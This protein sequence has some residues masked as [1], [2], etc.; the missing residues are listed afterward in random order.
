M[1]FI[2]SDWYSTFTNLS[3]NAFKM[4]LV[5]ESL[6]PVGVTK[7]KSLLQEKCIVRLL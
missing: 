4:L 7:I 1:G 5:E 3:E 2:K 6:K